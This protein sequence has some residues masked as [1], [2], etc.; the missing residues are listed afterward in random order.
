LPTRARDVHGGVLRLRET[1]EEAL[2]LDGHVRR[3][4]DRERAGGEGFG[5]GGEGGFERGLGVLHRGEGHAV[6]RV[7]GLEELAAG[8]G[9]PGV[10]HGVV[11]ARRDAVDLALARP[12]GRVRA[13]GGF[14]VDARRL[15]EEP[16]AHLEAEVGAR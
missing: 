9:H 1:R 11:A 5:G 6:R 16:D 10:V 8:V 13:G 14:G 3:A 15:L 4:D 7:D 12:D 2:L